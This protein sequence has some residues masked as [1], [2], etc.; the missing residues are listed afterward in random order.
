MS[1]VLPEQ[2]D[3]PSSDE[4]LA[5]DAERT[6][7][8]E[9][10]HRAISQFLQSNGYDALLLTQAANF[11]WF[12]SG[13][14][15]FQ[16]GSA[17]ATAALFITPEARVVVSNNIDSARI[18][19]QILPQLGFQLKERDWKASWELFLKDLCRGRR[20]AGDHGCGF[21]HNVS[22]QLT[23]MRQTLT[24]L[25]RQRLKLLGRLVAHAVEATAR[26]CQ[27][28]RTEAELAGELAHRLI[29]RQVVPMRIQV[30]ADEKTGRYRNWSYGN[31]RVERSCTIS[32]IGRQRGLCL[33]ASRTVC[34]GEVP[35]TLQRAHRR[36]ALV[37]A[38]GMHFS[39]AGWEIGEVWKRIQRIYEKFGCANEWRLAAQAEIIGYDVCEEPVIPESDF[40]LGDGMAVH[41]HP[42]VGPALLGDSVL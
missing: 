39:Q 21:T 41:W 6:A 18:F 36:A 4:I 5:F 29:K 12:T 34:V 7:D 13:G 3:P 23:G 26:S 16:A 15:C 32:A 22:K 37:H 25:E 33:G 30:A 38:T 17:E 14:D 28:G 27:P 2:I 40:R 9:Q 1:S 20:V 42:S 24:S 19:D 8:I 10:K 31:D 11:A 35:E